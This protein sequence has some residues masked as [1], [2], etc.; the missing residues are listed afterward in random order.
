MRSKDDLLND[1]MRC[2]AIDMAIV[3]ETWLT[4]S[5]MDV[6]WMES[7]GFIKDGYQIS[8]VN[9]IG[10]EA[11]GIAVIH[12]GIIN[13]IKVTQKQHRSFESAHWMTTSYIPNIL[14]FP[15]YSASQKIINTM[16]TDD[17]T[18]Y[19]MDQK[20]SFRNTLIC[21]DFNIHMAQKYKY[22]MT[23]WKL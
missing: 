2:E 12:R 13:V 20:A 17:I 19:L 9:R 6:I 21:G 22:S 14:D 7:N 11:G 1:Y 5:E 10:K 15:P 23:W 18:N 4:N 8:A 3:T 16:L